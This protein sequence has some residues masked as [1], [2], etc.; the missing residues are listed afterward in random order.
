MRLASFVLKAS[1]NAGFGADAEAQLKQLPG[2][3]DVLI[4]DPSDTC[5][6]VYDDKAVTLQT[7]RQALQQAGYDCQIEIVP[8]VKSSCC[9]ACS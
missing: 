7:L 3:S 9:G 1:H 8:A 2:V 6:V 4:G 5:S